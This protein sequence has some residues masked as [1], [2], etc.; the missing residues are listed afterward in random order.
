MK[1]AGK[2]RK[3]SNGEREIVAILNDHGLPAR[4]VPLSGAMSATGFGGD[5]LVK[6]GDGECTWEVK[7]RGQGFKRLEAWMEEAT[8]V[9]FRAD[10][11]DWCVCLRLDDYLKDRG[12][13]PSEPDRA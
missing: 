1:A 8:V 10:R 12:L 11:G 2:R 9:A 4:R 3:G 5:V 7:R 6:D 13:V